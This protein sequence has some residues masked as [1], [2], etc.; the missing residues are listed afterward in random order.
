MWRERYSLHSYS[1]H[2]YMFGKE[3]DKSVGKYL[4]ILAIPA[5]HKSKTCFTFIRLESL[6]K[7]AGQNL[8]DFPDSV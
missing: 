7:C 5:L 4:C 1:I 2:S 3:E 8:M 6:K